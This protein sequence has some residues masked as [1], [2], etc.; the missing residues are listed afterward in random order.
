MTSDL[1]ARISPQR[2]ARMAGLLYLVIIVLGLTGELVVRAGI[3]ANG[4]AAATAANIR[5]SA[6]LFRF[7]FFAD[8]VML[9]CDIALAVLL[10]VLL[11]PVSKTL[12]L[13][14]MCFRL[15]QAALIGGNLLHYHAAIIALG[16]PEYAALLGAEELNALAALFLDLHSHGYDL[17][18]LPFGLSCL[19]L[20]WLVYRSG[21]LPRTLGVLL[22]AAGIVYLVGSYT[23]FLFPAHVETVMPIYLVAIV[24]ESA[25]CLWLLFKGVDAAEWQRQEREA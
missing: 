4:D 15:V 5:A 11:R 13:M 12:A 9:L 8:S 21:F 1:K 22:A 6:G 10:Y 20:G 7:G 3:V 2:L 24:A 18:L 16:S 17:G 19:L 25:M 23:R 14:A